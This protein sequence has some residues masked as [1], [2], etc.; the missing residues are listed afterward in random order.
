MAPDAFRRVGARRA[1]PGR[2][3]SIGLAFMLACNPILAQTRIAPA[4]GE[5]HDQGDADTPIAFDIPAQP[6]ESALKAFSAVAGVGLFYES[7]LIRGRRSVSVRGLL[8][9]EAALRRLLQDTRLSARSFDRGT[10][11]I[12]ESTPADLPVG[13]GSAKAKVAE[14]ASYLARLQRSMDLAFCGETPG[15]GDP[16][17]LV[18]R[19]WIAPSGKVSRAELW[20]GSGSDHRDRAYIAAIGAVTIGAPPPVTMPQPV[21]MMIDMRA[22]HAAANCSRAGVE[23][24]SA[25]HD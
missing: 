20:S 15:P 8:P 16:E 17:D 22:S 18:A 13:L 4:T 23:L 3:L 21:N 5:Q 1:R 14:F 9:A 19:V 7:S 12:L 25:T 10:I 2:R 11:T 24:R 6:L